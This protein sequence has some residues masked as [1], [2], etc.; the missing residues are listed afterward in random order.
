MPHLLATYPRQFDRKPR[1]ILQSCL[2]IYLRSD[3][4]GK[5]GAYIGNF[6]VKESQKG[7]VATSN[8]FVLVEWCCV[9][10]EEL[11][12]AENLNEALLKQVCTAEAPLLD[13]CVAPG[14]HSP[15]DRS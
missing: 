2:R 10:E 12:K 6:L 15:V 4:T 11:A 5:T 7:V 14:Q 3:A 9:V 13:K 8:A 1:K